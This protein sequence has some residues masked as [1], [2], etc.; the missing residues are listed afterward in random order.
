MGS[1]IYSSQCSQTMPARPSNKCKLHARRALVSAEDE[2]KSIVFG[3]RQGKELGGY[4]LS[5]DFCVP[6]KS[7]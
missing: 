6:W 2:A 7:H 4:G 5:F 3:M 1:K